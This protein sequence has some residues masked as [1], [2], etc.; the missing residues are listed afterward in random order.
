MEAVT[1]TVRV[2]VL[3][4]N[5]G[6]L[7]AAL[8][9]K[10]ELGDEV[11]VT[12]ISAADRFLF[13]PSLIWLPFG[14]RRA[15]DI[16]FPL[17]PTFESH[18]VHFVHAAATAIDP[19][20]KE[21]ATTAGRYSYDYLIVA[22][23]YRNQM[24]IIPGLE[25]AN[26]AYTITTLEDAEQ[27]GRG[28]RR[29]L[30]DP[31]PV[32]VAA[33][34]GAGCFG[35]AYEFLFNVSYQLKKH[36]LHKRVPL[37]YITSEPFLGH[38]GIG[39]LPGGEKLL[40]LFLKKEGITA[41]TGT[42]LDAVEPGKLRL[43]DGEIHDF[44]YAMLIPP[45]LGQEVVRDTPGLADE[46][47]YVPVLDTYQSQAYSDIYTVGVAAAV[48]TGWTSAVPL[49]VPKT[50]F[51]TEVQAHA[52]ARNIAAAVRGEPPVAHKDFADIPA[53]CIMD[54]GNNGVMILADKMLPPRHAAAMLPGPQ[55][56]AAKL[57]FEKYYLWKS[58]HGYVRLP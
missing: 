45:F 32:I 35:A 22:T 53:V 42:S 9:V 16:A 7:T 4:G 48:T 30:D 5:F 24:D 58:R 50:G 36:R 3:G 52:A 14:K 43:A 54:A 8:S 23:G 28:W 51:P 46:K 29:L 17:S 20:A 47:G 39:G 44:A 26:S 57:A 18:G 12:V 15:E 31:G 21:V 6:G 41:I 49:G 11:D 56:H 25:P 1:V 34:Q 40:K 37:T 10:H 38:F 55:A 19:V 13:N 27:A 2:L 33:T